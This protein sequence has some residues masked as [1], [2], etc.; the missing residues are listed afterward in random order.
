[1]FWIS[2]L[3]LTA[4]VVTVLRIRRVLG[5]SASQATEPAEEPPLYRSTFRER[6]VREKLESH[7][8]L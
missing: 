5:R 3:L 7:G 8:W 6:T 2:L 1:M 4:V